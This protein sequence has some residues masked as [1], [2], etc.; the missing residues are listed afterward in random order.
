MCSLCDDFYSVKD[1]CR[2]G[3]REAVRTCT[4]AGVK[5]DPTKTPEALLWIQKRY[6]KREKRSTTEMSPDANYSVSKLRR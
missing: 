4:S 5:V 2:P 1:P 3:V 6:R